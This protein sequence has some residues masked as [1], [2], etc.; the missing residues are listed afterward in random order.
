MVSNTSSLSVTPA[1]GGTFIFLIGCSQSYEAI[2][3]E[4]IT[5]MQIVIGLVRGQI[6]DCGRHALLWRNWDLA[7]IYFATAFEERFL[8]HFW[9]WRE[10]ST[11][12]SVRAKQISQSFSLS[13]K[14]LHWLSN[15]GLFRVPNGDRTTVIGSGSNLSR[16]SADIAGKW[17]PNCHEWVSSRYQASGW[18][19]DVRFPRRMGSGADSEGDWR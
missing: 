2:S 3:A 12:E 16:C 5:R 19:S 6:G 15:A 18:N 7:T 17:L 10:W 9:R 13:A 1:D 11:L 8:Y 4:L 14:C